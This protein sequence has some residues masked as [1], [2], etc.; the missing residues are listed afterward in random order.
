MSGLKNRLTIR[1]MLAGVSGRERNFI[2]ARPANAHYRP[3]AMD[4]FNFKAV[5][6]SMP[7]VPAPSEDFCA[8][9]LGAQSSSCK[10]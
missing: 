6:S 7:T 9:E 3:K 1:A 5:S 10:T 4:Y 2:V 8:S